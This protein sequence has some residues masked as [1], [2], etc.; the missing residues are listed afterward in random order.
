MNAST[1]R[2]VAFMFSCFNMKPAVATIPA[3]SNLWANMAM[4]SMLFFDRYDNWFV[5]HDL[6]CL[7]RV[8]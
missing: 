1:I 8:F 4:E 3:L 2:S 7:L 6:R 5:P